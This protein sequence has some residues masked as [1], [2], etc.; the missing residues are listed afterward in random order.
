MHWLSLLPLYQVFRTW[1]WLAVIGCIRISNI[2]EFNLIYKCTELSIVTYHGSW[3]HISVELLCTAVLQCG[4]DVL[5]E[6]HTN[7][8]Q[9]SE[10]TKHIILSN[11][12]SLEKTFHGSHATIFD[13][14]DIQRRVE[15]LNMEVYWWWVWWFLR[16]AENVHPE[17]DWWILHSIATV[18][19]LWQW[20]IY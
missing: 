8:T 11:W 10:T 15:W 9:Y 16:A 3:H 7:H 4:T 12:A 14:L 1:N 19:R 5:L 20:L 2:S 6:Y 18:H 13:T 17:F